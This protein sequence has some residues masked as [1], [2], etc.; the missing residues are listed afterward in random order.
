MKLLHECCQG[1]RRG[2]WLW[3]RLVRETVPVLLAAVLFWTGA[4]LFLRAC[5]GV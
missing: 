5:A 2:W 4:Y 3:W 1:F